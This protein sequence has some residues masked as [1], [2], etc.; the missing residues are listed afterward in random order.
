[1]QLDSNASLGVMR[2]GSIHI[3]RYK[4]CMMQ[5]GPVL[6]AARWFRSIMLSSPRC[7]ELRCPL[8][9]SC[10]PRC[11]WRLETLYD[12]AAADFTRAL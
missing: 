2:N 12:I 11:A 10:T 9:A 6:T 4:K 1:M 8:I 5:C 7:A 3:H